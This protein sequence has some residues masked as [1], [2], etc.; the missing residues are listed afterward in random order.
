MKVSVSK[1]LDFRT[2]DIYNYTGETKPGH[3]DRKTRQYLFQGHLRLYG[4][5]NHRRIRSGNIMPSYRQITIW[6]NFEN[7]GK[8]RVT[9]F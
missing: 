6:Y 5:Q 1:V 9:R 8:S 4:T 2:A 3:S 7:S